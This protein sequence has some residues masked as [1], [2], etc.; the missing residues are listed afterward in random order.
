MKQLHC[1]HTNHEPSQHL[2]I[3]SGAKRC[4][5][6]WGLMTVFRELPFLSAV[7]PTDLKMF[8]SRIHGSGDQP[9]DQG[10]F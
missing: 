2:D 10:V 9:Y 8:R 4:H 7:L 5:L 3:F 6:F 1:S